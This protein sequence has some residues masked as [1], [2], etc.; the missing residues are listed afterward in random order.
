M[1]RARKAEVVDELKGLFGEAGTV[2]VAHY[3]GMTVAEMSDLRSRMR[4]VGASFRVAKNRLA[5]RALDGTPVAGIAAL[6]AGPTGIAFS[7]DPVAAAKVAVAYAR[8]NAKL[9]VLGGAMGTNVLD[10][11]GVKALASLP[12]L[13]ELRGRIVGLFQAPAAK[14]ATVL[15]A[16]ATQVARV[17]SAYAKKEAA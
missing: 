15:Q 6:F 5:R 17:V 9:V 16:P 12:S 4:K 1:E 8:D 14:L 13:D 7:K 11:E 2:V 10:V 3:T